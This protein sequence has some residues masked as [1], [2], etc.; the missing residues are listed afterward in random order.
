MWKFQDFSV[1]LILREINFGESR[2]SKIANCAILGTVKFVELVNFSHQ[3][4]NFR[5]SQFVKMADFESR[6]SLIF[7]FTK[8]LSDKKILSFPH[9]GV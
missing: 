5:A 6:N 8:N 2:S 9:C 3:N 4:S 1:T 7:D